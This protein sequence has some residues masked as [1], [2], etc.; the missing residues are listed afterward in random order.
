MAPLVQIG[1]GAVVLRQN[2]QILNPV[3]LFDGLRVVAGLEPVDPAGSEADHV[4]GRSAELD[5]DEVRID[6]DAKAKRHDRVLEL[7]AANPQLASRIARAMDRWSA[8]AEPWRSAAREAVARV[9]AYPRL[10]DDVRE[11]VSK[12][13]ES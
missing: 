7:D 10:S 11:I 5:A 6:V 12:S 13:L 2:G 8:L 1:Q 9:A 3:G 4:L